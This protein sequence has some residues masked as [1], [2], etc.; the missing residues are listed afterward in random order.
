MPAALSNIW[1]SSWNLFQDCSSNEVQHS[2]SF[3]I[4]FYFLKWSVNTVKTLE[5]SFQTV[6]SLRRSKFWL[7][8]CLQNQMDFPSKILLAEDYPPSLSLTLKERG[9]R[10]WG[11]SGCD[12]LTLCSDNLGLLQRFA[13]RTSCF[14]VASL[15]VLRM[16]TRGASRKV[17]SLTRKLN[18]IKSLQRISIQRQKI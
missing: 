5:C 4:I 13:W 12:H 10:R 8:S 18:N 15:A 3:P 2:P 6:I 1:R 16:G 17:H 11:R 9:M 14:P 7:L